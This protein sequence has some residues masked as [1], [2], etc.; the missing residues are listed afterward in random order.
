MTI[1]VIPARSGSKRLKRKNIK[2]FHGKPIISYAIK[3]AKSCN[4]FSRII[5]STDCK[6]IK[7]IAEKYGAEVPFLRSKKLSDDYTITAE[8]II[9]TIK[10]TSSENCQY[11]FCI[12]PTAILITK[13]DLTKAFKKIKKVKADALFAV[14][15]NS[16]L[17]RSFKYNKKRDVIDFKWKKYSQYMSQ[18]LPKIYSDTG[19]FFIF[20]TKKYLAS[21][22]IL[23]KKTIPYEISKIKGIDLNTKDDLELLKAAYSFNIAKRT[24]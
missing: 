15:E 8:V 9:D 14:Y 7:K 6:K 23:S 17:M 3:I 12:Y 22:K 20:N 11:H 16:S 2:L 10:K 13:K 18:D 19:T 21:K 5:V 24:N 1:C 4:L